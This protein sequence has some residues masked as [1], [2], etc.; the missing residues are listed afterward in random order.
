MWGAHRL[1]ALVVASFVWLAWFVLCADVH[2]WLL[3]RQEN[4][5]F[6][7]PVAYA[8]GVGCGLGIAWPL[9]HGAAD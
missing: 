5:C 4:I 2:F 3:W 7:I 9:L 1:S 8:A 6:C